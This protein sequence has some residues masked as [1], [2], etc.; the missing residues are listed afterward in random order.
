MIFELKVPYLKE[1]EIELAANELLHRYAKWKGAAVRPPIDID[2]II[3]GYFGLDLVFIDLPA[4]LGIPDVLG[5]TFL[6]EKR[7][8]IDESLD[9]E[10]K[11]GRLAFT[12]AHETGHWELHRPLIEAAQV[13]APL[14]AKGDMPEQPS[15]VCRS[16]QKKAPAEWQADKFAACLLMPATEVR[17]TVRA[18][19][20]DRLP[21]WEGVEERRKN[22]ELDERLRDLAAEVTA[23]GGF[24]N[25]SNEAMRYRL[26][27]L[28]LVVD[29]SNP[30]RILL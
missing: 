28:K 12:L 6:K 3:E 11:E 21:T 19:C 4:F 9:L 29:A 1:S 18:L 25:V 27:D 30:Q 14:F 8:F 23:R 10:G 2:N 13:T 16:T 17:A 5:A 22:R 20:G 15:I 7:V 26:L 24:T